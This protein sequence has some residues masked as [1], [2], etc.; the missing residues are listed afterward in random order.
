MIRTIPTT[1]TVMVAIPT[2][3]LFGCVGGNAQFTG[4]PQFGQKDI[5]AD[6]RA[7][8]RGQFVISTLGRYEGVYT[9]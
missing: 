9:Y 8:H 7:P 1:T 4:S 3:F 2:P 5:S 6:I